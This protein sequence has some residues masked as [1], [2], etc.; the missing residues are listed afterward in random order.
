MIIL[1]ILG[2]VMGYFLLG[3]LA[4]RILGWLQKI[5]TD[6]D[7]AGWMVLGWPVFAVIGLIIGFIALLRW[8]GN[9]E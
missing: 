1:V 9:V 2:G 7:Q 3:A 5:K 8:I 6:M 4:C